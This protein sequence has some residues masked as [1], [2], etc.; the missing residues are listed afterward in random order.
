LKFSPPTILA[1]SFILSSP[2]STNSKGVIIL[3]EID[4]N[5]SGDESISIANMISKLS[6]SFQIFAISHQ[7]HLSSKAEQHILV[8]KDSKASYAK[9]LNGEERVNEIARIVGGEN[10]N[11]EAL[12]F[13]KGLF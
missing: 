8:T 11:K 3:D 1:I 12:E 6:K 4:A 2:F 9:V 7:P 13:A 5:V 10:F